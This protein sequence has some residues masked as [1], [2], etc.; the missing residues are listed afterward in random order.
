MVYDLFWAVPRA[1]SPVFVFHAPGLVWG[2]TE[3]VGSNFIILRSRTRF[4]RYR[5]CQVPYSCFALPDWFWTVP[6]TS[7]P[8]FMFC[9][10]GAILDDTEG[11]RFRF[12]VLRSRTRFGRYRGSRVPFS[13]FALPNSF[14]TVAR[15]LGPVSMFRSL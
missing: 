12:H 2:C 5:G 9:A 10:P 6:R 3:G 15:T 14:S 8:V 1:S 7:G 11:A 4:R 13:C